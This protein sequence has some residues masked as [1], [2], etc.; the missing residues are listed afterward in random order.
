MASISLGPPWSRASVQPLMA[1]DTRM[2]VPFA[3]SASTMSNT[4]DIA[5]AD[6]T[7]LPPNFK[8]LYFIAGCRIRELL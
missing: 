7:E 8:T 6:A 1:L 2:T 3:A 5:V 4:L